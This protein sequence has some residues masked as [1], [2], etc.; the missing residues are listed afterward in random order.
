MRRKSPCAGQSACCR[1]LRPSEVHAVLNL[2]EPHPGERTFDLTAQDIHVP[3]NVNVVQIV[4]SQFH[5]S[6]DRSVDAH[7]C[8][9]SRA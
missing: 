8:K 7:R 9:C 2:Q 5:I 6:F 4:P 1:N 3:R